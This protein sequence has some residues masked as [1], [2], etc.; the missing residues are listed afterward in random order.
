MLCTMCYEVKQSNPKGVTYTGWKEGNCGTI[1][2]VN[3]SIRH[4]TRSLSRNMISAVPL[5]MDIAI[6]LNIDKTLDKYK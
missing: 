2:E 6:G 4:H 1:S 3:R 5:V